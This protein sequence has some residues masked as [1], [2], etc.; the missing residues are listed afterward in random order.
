[1]CSTGMKVMRMLSKPML[2][3]L[4]LFMKVQILWIALLVVV[5]M[6][7]V[8]VFLWFAAPT[9]ETRGTISL[10]YVEDPAGAGLALLF[11]IFVIPAVLIT[12]A[13]LLYRRRHRS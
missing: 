1:M 10:D 12:I 7:G 8:E 13:M 6:L 3:G 4:G 9:P 5:A 2:R 11:A